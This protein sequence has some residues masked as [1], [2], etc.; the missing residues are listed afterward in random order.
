MFCNKCGSKID[1]KS[2]FCGKC[3]TKVDKETSSTNKV[4]GSTN[5]NNLDSFIG[6]IS[7]SAEKQSIDSDIFTKID[8]TENRDE[9]ENDNTNNKINKKKIWFKQ[10]FAGVKKTKAKKKP[11]PKSR[12]KQKPKPKS[13]QKP[14]PSGEASKKKVNMK[15]LIPAILVPVIIIAGIFVFMFFNGK[16]SNPNNDVVK[17]FKTTLTQIE[18]HTKKNMQIPDFTIDKSEISKV[19][20]KERYLKI[21]NAKGGLLNEDI[22]G[23]LKG[24]SLKLSEKQDVEKDLFN[25]KLTFANDKNEEIFA[26]IFSSSELATLNLPSLYNSKVGIH[27]KQDES[28]EADDDNTEALV[29]NTP[30]YDDA[31]QALELLK[32]GESSFN[33]FK[34]SIKDKSIL[35]VNDII[36]NAQFKLVSD[37]EQTKKKEYSTI[38]ENVALLESLKVF[39]TEIKEDDFNKKFQLLLSYFLNGE[40]LELAEFL[41]IGSPDTLITS[42][43]N[44]I[45]VIAP[46]EDEIQ[47]TKEAGVSLGQVVRDTAKK[48]AKKPIEEQTENTAIITPKETEIRLVINEDQTIRSISFSIV[49]DGILMSTTIDIEELENKLSINTNVKMSKGDSNLILD[50]L[51]LN[52]QTSMD[53]IKRGNTISLTTFLGDKFVFDSIDIYNLKTNI[54]NSKLDIV[55]N[56]GSDEF[57][58]NYDLS[59]KYKEESELKRLDIDSLKIN[60]DDGLY[61]FYFEFIGHILKRNSSSIEMINSNNVIFIDN[62][63]NQETDE[64]K[65][66]I[67]NNWKEFLEKFRNR[68][69]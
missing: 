66:K 24:L 33:V 1:D 46:K 6:N 32:N 8:K 27:F 10:L 9:V 31:S 17:A 23:S 60:I 2:N 35:L 53:E 63:S 21:K 12:P 15:I 22:L 62:M 30:Y 58:I 59:G 56:D 68:K 25:T 14:R 42:I 20:E 43:D 69:W 13:K 57:F 54:Y 52:E 28:K 47:K 16:L 49:I 61:K 65:E 26:E 39:L 45:Q 34:N 41:T 64:I 18:K 5:T 11:K 29:I 4:E 44:T 55:A 36:K 38:I 7:K 3:G 40:N 51:S 50:I 19:V 67:N 37:N 48:V